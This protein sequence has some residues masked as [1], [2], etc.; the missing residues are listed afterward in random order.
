MK[1][2]ANVVIFARAEKRFIAK[3]MTHESM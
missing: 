2:E 1:A 3:M